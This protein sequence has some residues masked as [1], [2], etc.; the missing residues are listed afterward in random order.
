MKCRQLHKLLIRNSGRD[1]SYTDCPQIR[2]VIAITS[3]SI[4]GADSRLFR[5]NYCAIINEAFPRS[6]VC[7]I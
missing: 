5:H 1:Y 2:A 7:I 3:Y 6:V 4:G